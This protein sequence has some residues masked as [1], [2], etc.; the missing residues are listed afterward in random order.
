LSGRT[1]STIITGPNTDAVK[2]EVNEP[3]IRGAD[4]NGFINIIVGDGTRDTFKL[5]VES[6]GYE[7][8]YNLEDWF[9]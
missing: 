6:G 9:R 1:G 7:V 3:P 2:I 8:T 5:I 4:P